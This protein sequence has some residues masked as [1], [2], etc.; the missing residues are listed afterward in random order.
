MCLA[1]RQTP[2]AG[3]TRS[4]KNSA[5]AIRSTENVE[6]ALFESVGRSVYC[7]GLNN[8]A[9]SRKNRIFSCSFR[10][11]F[12]SETFG[13]KSEQTRAVHH[14]KRGKPLAGAA[15]ASAMADHQDS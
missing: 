12:A 9:T 10:R 15:K 11:C 13:E 3:R 2:R 7:P 8:S 14:V 1:G 6:E 5:R 4:P